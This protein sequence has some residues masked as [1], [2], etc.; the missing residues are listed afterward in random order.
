MCVA[1]VFRVDRYCGIAQHSLGSG[2]GHREKAFSASERVTQVPQTALFLF[3]DNLEVGDGGMQCRVPVDQPL[4][5]IDQAL[6]VES[7]E[8]FLYCLD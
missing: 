4:T 1:L 3:T 7:N 8:D 5:A 6:V 2:C